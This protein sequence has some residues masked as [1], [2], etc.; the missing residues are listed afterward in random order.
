MI[1][2]VI[3]VKRA[4]SKERNSSGAVSGQRMVDGRA[5]VTTYLP[6]RTAQTR[7]TGGASALNKE[8]TVICSGNV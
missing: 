8:D 6:Q 2:D 3:D 5:P 7:H 4:R 1:V